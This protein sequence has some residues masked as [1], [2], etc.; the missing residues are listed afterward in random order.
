MDKPA[1]NVGSPVQVRYEQRESGPPIILGPA[2]Q[3][4]HMDQPYSRLK[5][6]LHETACEVWAVV[7]GVPSS[8]SLLEAA[9]A[10]GLT[11]PATQKL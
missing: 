8:L 1:L 10:R 2:R 3:P 7:W 6:H 5:H 11:G 9:G 4:P